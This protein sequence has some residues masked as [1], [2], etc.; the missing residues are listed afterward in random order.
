MK[1]KPR[2]PELPTSSF[3]IELA[4]YAVLVGTYFL[5]VLHYLGPFIKQVYDRDKRWYAALALALMIAQGMGLEILTTWLL[6]TVRAVR[7]KSP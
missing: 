2:E 7:A 3:L 6:K 1:A 4:I 5:L